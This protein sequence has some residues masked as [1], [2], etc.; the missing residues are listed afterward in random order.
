MNFKNHFLVSMPHLVDI[1]FHK[2]IIYICEHNQDGAMGIIINKNLFLDRKSLILKD[3][4]LHKIAPELKIFY[5]GPV[6]TN[7]GL[8]LHSCDY[9]N[10]DSKII[11]KKISITSN[12][13]IM[14]DLSRGK[15]PDKYRLT[16]GHAGWSSKQ[17]EREFE[18]GDWLLLPANYNF[19]FDIP[20]EEK[21]EEAT[22]MFG[23][24]ILQINGST[25]IS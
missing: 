13:K 15:G 25:G 6:Q 9:T 17:L 19:I 16:F 24:D 8:F 22:K 20:D 14:N 5:G 23:I 18:N 4:Q 12:E 3:T 2:S 21:W 11:T 1:Y 7:H 10:E